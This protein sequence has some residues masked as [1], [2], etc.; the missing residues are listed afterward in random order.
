[1]SSDSCST[2]L[3]SSSSSNIF[4]QKNS[5]ICQEKD[6]AYKIELISPQSINA[7]IKRVQVILNTNK[8]RKD[9]YK[10]IKFTK[11]GHFKNK[12]KPSIILVNYLNRIIEYTEIEF[13]TLVLSLIYLERICKERIFLNEFNVHR[14]L[15]LSVIMAYKYNED[16]KC[17]K[18]Y[19]SKIGG[20][21]SKEI[22]HL[23]YEFF[24]FIDCKFFVENEEF[25]NYETLLK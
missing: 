18:E 4:N 15:L 17:D 24:D 13:S 21:S 23:E 7:Y 10:K 2:S 20:I 16:C 11:D 19:L 22:A 5:K 14:I 25:K 12:N 9:Y 8:K 3:S 1:M 6:N